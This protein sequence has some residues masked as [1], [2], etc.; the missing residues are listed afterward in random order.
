MDITDSGKNGSQVRAQ[1]M[2]SR[3]PSGWSQP[4]GVGVSDAPTAD[5]NTQGFTLRAGGRV[6]PARWP[7][8]TDL[9]CTR[10]LPGRAASVPPVHGARLNGTADL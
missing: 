1:P 5:R 6:R 3:T 2:M 8:R 7:V 10:P 4:K 9:T